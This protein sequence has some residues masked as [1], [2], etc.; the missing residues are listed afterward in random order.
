MREIGTGTAAI[1]TAAGRADVY[2]NRPDRRNAMNRDVIADLTAAIQ[3][4]DGDDEIR[5]ITLL[6][7]GPVFCAGMDLDMMYEYDVDDHDTLHQ[8]LGQLFDTID[9]TTTPVVAGIKRAGIAGG[10]ELT[11]PADFR[12]LGREAKYGVI[13]VNLGI[14]PHQGATQRLPRLIGLAKA[15]ELVLTGDWI[16]PDV[17]KQCGLVTDV[18]PDDDVDAR[19]RSLA[20]ELTEKA[21][22]GVAA[23]LR[24]FQQTFDV[25][26]EDGLEFTH[27]LALH[28]YRTDDRKEG[29]EAQLEGREP[30]YVGQ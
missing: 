19:A 16:D 30:E 12:I 17:A 11:L 8:E 13:E 28:V 5:A 9:N 24:A 18:V 6:G 23:A 4:V 25:P 1:E 21:P 2:L 20:D 3:H 10:F 22:R 27:Q 26:L 14:F 7:T 29:F 15:K